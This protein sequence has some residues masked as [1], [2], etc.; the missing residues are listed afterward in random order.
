MVKLTE[1]DYYRA[2]DPEYLKDHPEEKEALLAIQ[3]NCKPAWC[4]QCYFCKQKFDNSL[5]FLG[6]TCAVDQSIDCPPHTGIA[7]ECPL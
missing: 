6:L 5:N 2:N 1:R 4:G 3:R 7:K